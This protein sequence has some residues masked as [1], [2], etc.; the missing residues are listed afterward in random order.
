MNKTVLFFTFLKII[1]ALM[2]IHNKAGYY[3]KYLS[4]TEGQ[5]LLKKNDA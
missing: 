5:N 3:V 1:I 4:E 2:I